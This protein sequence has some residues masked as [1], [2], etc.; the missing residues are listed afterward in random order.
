M[1]LP[2][3]EG[4]L[5]FVA[6]C[7]CGAGPEAKDEAGYCSVC[8]L[9][10]LPLAREALPRDHVEIVLTPG[11]AVVTDRGRRHACNEDDA[12]LALENP[13]GLMPISIL[14][15]C[16]GVSSSQHADEASRAAAQAACT[17]LQTNVQ[18]RKP[19]SDEMALREAV[20][21]AHAAACALPSI[22]DL[23]KGPPGTTLVAALA[24]QGVVTLCWVGDSR[25]Y[26][27]GPHET[28]LLTHDHSWVNEV[29]DA[30]EMSEEDA[31]CAP[32]A[33]GITRCLG[34]LNGD[35][36]DDSPEPSLRTFPVAGPGWLLLCTDGLWNY[37]PQTEQIAALVR[38]SPPDT[39]AL[40]LCRGLINYALAQ[41]GR[42][43][44]T[45]AMLAVD[46]LAVD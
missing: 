33:H 21:A 18:Q 13:P 39:D 20:R 15:V 32:E 12:V 22:P 16:D 7:R 35:T 42:D 10:W 28:R 9:R 38:Q 40:S 5:A 46:T 2:S 44:I 24:R 34:L 25:A 27:L 14:V 8:G 36:P 37:A 41:G 19:L 30:G 43:N 11:F 1:S 23:A 26:W 6:R 29:V 3:P 45:A 4:I 31:L 17:V